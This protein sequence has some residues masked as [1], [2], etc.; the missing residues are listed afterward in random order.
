MLTHLD[1]IA[2]GLALRQ[3]LETRGGALNDT[4]EGNSGAVE[5]ELADLDEKSDG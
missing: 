2:R 4:D 5:V 3:L 1:D